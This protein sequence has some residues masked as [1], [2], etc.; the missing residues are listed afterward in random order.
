MKSASTNEIKVIIGHKPPVFDFPSDWH[1]VTTDSNNK[2]DFF[3][4]DNSIWT[5]NGDDNCLSEYSTLIPLAK[6]LKSMPEVKTIR[7]AQ[8]R[9]VVSK[10]LLV[11]CMYRLRSNFYL[12]KK[13]D[14][15]FYDF[16]EITKLPQNDFLLPS[17]FTVNSKLEKAYQFETILHHYKTCH[18][19]EDLLG[20]LKDA[21]VCGGITVDDADAILHSNKFLIGGMGLGV[22]PTDFFIKV[23]EQA[24][25]IAIFYYHNSWIKRNDNYQCRN[26]GFLLEI[27]TSYLVLKELK[28]RS[29]DITTVLGYVMIISNDYNYQIGTR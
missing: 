20:F 28:T 16:D 10:S 7:I 3:V 11:P 21:V 4:E 12:F 14:L 2:K 9:K 25:K 13:Q 8:Y 23:C 24:E 26:L 19:I 18:Y 22:Y 17:F 1:L 5:K 27:L 29:I 6:K 15:K